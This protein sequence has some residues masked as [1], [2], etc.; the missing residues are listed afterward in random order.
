MQSMANNSRV[1][2]TAPAPSLP[3][4]L[5][6]PTC[7][8]WKIAGLLGAA[9]LQRVV[10]HIPPM[11][12]DSRASHP[13]TPPH[14]PQPTPSPAACAAAPASCAPPRDAHPWL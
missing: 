3:R 11:N 2:T 9:G 7:T 12:T 1:N 14:S 10:Q 6:I 8:P 5:P 13:S 4:R